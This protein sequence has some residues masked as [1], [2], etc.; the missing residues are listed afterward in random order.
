MIGFMAI[1]V[2]LPLFFFSAFWVMIFWGMAAS[3]VHIRTIS[4]PEA[5]AVT[6]GLWLALAPLAFSVGKL[7]GRMGSKT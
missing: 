7:A 6:F 5:L 2:A 1:V 3:W 4:Y